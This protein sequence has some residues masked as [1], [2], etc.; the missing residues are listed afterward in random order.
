M[1]SAKKTKALF[2]L[3][4]IGDSQ[5]GKTSIIQRFCDGVFT[6]S[7]IS[8]IGCDFKTKDILLE[9]CTVAVEIWDTAGQEKFKS[10]TKN[11]FRGADGF[12]LT[13][14]ITNE[15]T[16][17]NV[18]QWLKD[19]KAFA[20]ETAKIIL[21]GNKCDLDNQRQVKTDQG[22][23]IAKQYN[24]HFFETS[25]R[26]NININ[27]LFNKIVNEIYLFKKADV[28]QSSI[29]ASAGG[30]KLTAPINKPQKKDC[31]SK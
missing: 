5:V 6:G 22:I 24:Y 13:Y 14:D 11:M 17:K 20:K 3:L 31:C 1:A 15:K 26:D 16:F 19:I 8:T 18:N 2:K 12:I 4:L 7:S 10:M 21:A 27:E 9:N 28:T 30:N 23:N 25:C 29:G